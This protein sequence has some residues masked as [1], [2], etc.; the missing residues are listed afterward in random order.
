MYPE[1]VQFTQQQVEKHY[2]TY[3]GITRVQQESAA[4]KYCRER[5]DAAVAVLERVIGKDV[6][7]VLLREMERRENREYHRKQNLMMAG[8][9]LEA[10]RA[11]NGHM[12]ER[13]FSLFPTERA[14]YRT[15]YG[16]QMLGIKEVLEKFWTG[17]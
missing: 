14:I 9:A 4:E 17:E 7:E 11:A 16:M 5:M 3:G 15:H 13:D 6:E 8:R 10:I 1:Y 12:D 2:Q